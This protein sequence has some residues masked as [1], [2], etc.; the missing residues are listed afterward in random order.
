LVHPPNFYKVK[1]GRV[2]KYLYCFTMSKKILFVEDDNNLVQSL[3][4]VAKQEGFQ[5]ISAFDGERGAELA[6]KEEPDLILLDLILPKK[7]GFDVLKEIKANEKLAKIPIIIL[8]NLEDGKDLE[9]A[10]SLGANTYLVKTNYSMEEVMRKIKE[11][12]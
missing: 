4:G 7:S 6:K 5:F 10:L 1:V 11:L 9:K 8:T 3:K 2:N 12:L